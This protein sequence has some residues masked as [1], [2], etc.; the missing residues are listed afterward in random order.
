MS[1]MAES[2]KV[3]IV[4]TAAAVAILIGSAFLLWKS[5]KSTKAAD[6][7]PRRANFKK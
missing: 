1:S 5:S 3:R 4:A 7:S 6:A 2:Q